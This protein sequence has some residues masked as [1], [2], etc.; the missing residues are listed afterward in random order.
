MHLC[1]VI[2]YFV[3]AY[4]R[5]KVGGIDF[6]I[7]VRKSASDSGQWKYEKTGVVDINLGFSENPQ[8]SSDSFILNRRV[9]YYTQYSE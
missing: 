4:N 9:Y 2:S 6:A 1:F 3:A 7:I 5:G 8:I